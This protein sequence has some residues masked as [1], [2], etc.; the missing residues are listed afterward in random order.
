MAGTFTATYDADGYA[1]ERTCT[2]TIHGQVA[3]DAQ[4]TQQNY[5]YDAIG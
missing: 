3:A 4:I 5:R 2:R 1:L